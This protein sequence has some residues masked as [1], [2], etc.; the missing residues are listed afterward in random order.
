VGAEL[1]VWIGQALMPTG[2]DATPAASW[3]TESLGLQL[4]LGPEE[5]HGRAPVG[6]VSRGAS[7]TVE[8]WLIT[9]QT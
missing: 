4:A 3:G 1:P 8:V 7:S 9:W 2:S 5:G 6:N